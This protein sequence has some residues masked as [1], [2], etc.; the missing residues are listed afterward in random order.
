MIGCKTGN[1]FDLESNY[2]VYF[3]DFYEPLDHISGKF[4]FYSTIGSDINLVIWHCHSRHKNNYSNSEFLILDYIASSRSL[5]HL[6]MK[7][8]S[9]S[10]RIIIFMHQITLHQDCNCQT[11]L[12]GSAG[13]NSNEATGKVAYKV[14][15]LTTGALVFKKH[16]CVH[17]ML[18]LAGAASGFGLSATIP[19]LRREEP[20]RT[21]RGHS[22]MSR[23]HYRAIAAV[24]AIGPYRSDGRLS[25]PMDR[26]G[27]IWHDHFTEFRRSGDLQVAG[28][29]LMQE[30]DA[31]TN[32][33]CRR[34]RMCGSEAGPLREECAPHDEG[35]KIMPPL[36]VDEAEPARAPGIS[37]TH[38]HEAVGEVLPLG[39]VRRGN[40][41]WFSDH[42]SI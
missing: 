27:S 24:A 33:S 35:L 10:L 40:R 38:F 22:H 21:T 30:I 17:D 9:N 3:S 6:D 23:A 37:E 4:I 16:V 1:I 18:V 2:P 14:S 42:A 25:Q 26:P 36:M 39:Q 13:I 32:K 31:A 8:F 12:T 34:L 28:K 7:Y 20:I 15:R 5:M 41:S 29:G 19:F 11:H